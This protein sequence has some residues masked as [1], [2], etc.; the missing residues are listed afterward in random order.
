M[1]AFS[2]LLN[3]HLSILVRYR[4]QKVE[5]LFRTQDLGLF[6]GVGHVSGVKSDG[7]IEKSVYPS[8]SPSA[9]STNVVA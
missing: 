1:T 8:A 7:S 9:G 4:F 6:R 3:T 5:T 2:Q